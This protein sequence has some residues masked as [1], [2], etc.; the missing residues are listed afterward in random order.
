MDNF[1]KFVSKYKNIMVTVE[2]A[3][4]LLAFLIGANVVVMGIILLPLIL[5]LIYV[6]ESAFDDDI[7]DK[8]DKLSD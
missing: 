4:V 6:P 2:M 3:L 7:D 8:A 1:K 5:L